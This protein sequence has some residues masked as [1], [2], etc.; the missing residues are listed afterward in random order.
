MH[1]FANNPELLLSTG[2]EGRLNI[3]WNFPLF[4]IWPP[5]SSSSRRS[6]QTQL[7]WVLMRLRASRRACRAGIAHP[8]CSWESRKPGSASW[9]VFPFILLKLRFSHHR[10]GFSSPQKLSFSSPSASRRL[11]GFHGLTLVLSY[12][13]CGISGRGQKAWHLDDLAHSHFPHKLSLHLILLLSHTALSVP[14][15]PGDSDF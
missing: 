8:F 14:F 10:Q 6:L 4:W 1:S 11:A 15:L 2:E 5:S 12:Q 3:S 7:I 9:E 13:S